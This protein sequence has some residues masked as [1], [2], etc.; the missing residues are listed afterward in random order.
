MNKN[1]PRDELEFVEGDMPFSKRFGD[2]FYS[3]HDGRLES[4]HVFL[5]GNNLPARW[6][7]AGNFTIGELGFGTGLNFLETWRQ[8]KLYRRAD[9]H[10]HFVS[11][12]AYPME[13]AAMRRAVG[14]W[15][16]I[17]KESEALA[18][19]WSELS[20]VPT[21]WTMDA[22]TTLTVI[23]ADAYDG[24]NDWQ[25]SADAWFLDGFSPAR[26]P[27]MWSLELMTQLAART[28]HGGTFASYTAAG[29]VRRNLAAAG[30]TVHKKRGFAGKRDMTCGVKTRLV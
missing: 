25:G 12:E 13:S 14:A 3:R 4:E 6:S 26:N 15:D 1:L 28:N 30:F 10:L 18:A 29:W 11:F 23:V 27:A 5:H 22:Q 16:Q 17:V 9:A 19:Q 7:Q 2:H 20:V 24:M 21:P 8:W